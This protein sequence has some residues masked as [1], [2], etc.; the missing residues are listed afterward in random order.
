[1]SKEKYMALRQ[2]FLSHGKALKALNFFY[3]F[4]P[5]SV[6]AIYPVMVILRC[7]QGFDM[8]LVRMIS[9]PL[10]VLLGVT[11]IRKLI[12]RPRPYEVYNITPIVS[13]KTK[14]ESFPSRHSASA[15]IIAM[16]AFSLSPYL[17]AVMLF[18]ALSVALTRILAGVHFVSDVVAGSLFSVVIGAVFFIIL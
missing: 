6:I 8:E 15:F 4:L 16:S 7:F 13:K 14:G 10:S 18:I 2:W 9:V 5:A 11:V 3:K 12:N 17:A 1:M